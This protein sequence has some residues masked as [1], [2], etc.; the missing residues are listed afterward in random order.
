MKWPLNLDVL[1]HYGHFQWNCE[2]FSQENTKILQNDNFQTGALTKSKWRF[3][4][5]NKNQQPSDQ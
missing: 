1:V 3:F 2:H 5:K 4:Y